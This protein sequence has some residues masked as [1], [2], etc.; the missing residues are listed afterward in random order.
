MVDLVEEIRENHIG[1]TLLGVTDE[2]EHQKRHQQDDQPKR[3]VPPNL[4]H[5]N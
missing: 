3:Y 5:Y 2:F 1:G 4:R